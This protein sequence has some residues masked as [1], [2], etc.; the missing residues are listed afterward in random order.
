MLADHLQHQVQPVEHVFKDRVGMRLAGVEDD[1]GKDRHDLFEPR[2]F[3]QERLVQS[4]HVRPELDT[5]HAEIA[6]EA[7]GE[8][9]IQP[10]ILLIVQLELIRDVD[11]I[12][13]RFAVREEGGRRLQSDLM[14][15]DAYPALLGD[16]PRDRFRDRT[17]R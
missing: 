9:G 14:R 2:G 11:R 4:L 5:G 17:D 16:I 6:L 12:G 7:L 15:D 13:G 10:G 8:I 3:L 1:V